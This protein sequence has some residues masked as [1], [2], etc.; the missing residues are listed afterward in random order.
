MSRDCFEVENAAF[1][2]DKDSW[3]W[4]SFFLASPHQLGFLH[5]LLL[6]GLVCISSLNQMFS[7][8]VQ[9]SC[10]VFFYFYAP[11]IN[12]YANWTLKGKKFPS[13]K[14]RLGEAFPGKNKNPT[15]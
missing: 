6:S 15:L 10:F 5:V 11:N 12:A 8:L 3:E 9:T 14:D 13:N 7:F 2:K 1:V 4:G